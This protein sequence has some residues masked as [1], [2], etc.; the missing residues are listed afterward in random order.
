MSKTRRDM[1]L[2][3]AAA[4]LLPAAALAD[5][6]RDS[7]QARRAVERGEALALAEILTRVRADLGGEVVGVEFERKRERW[8]YEFKVIDP[9][10][11]LWEVYVDAATAA[12]LKREGH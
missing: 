6:E 8:V 5:R 10:G 1:I 2:A 7:D 11:R 12:I 9:D 3:L 4:T